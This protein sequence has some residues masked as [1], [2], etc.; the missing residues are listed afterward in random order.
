V[1]NSLKQMI[2]VKD[3]A[4]RIPGARIMGNDELAIDNLVQLSEH[5]EAGQLCWCSEKN[6]EK[7]S[8]VKQGAI[9]C[10]NKTPTLS[11]NTGC[12]YILVD[13]PRLAFKNVV[14]AFFVDKTIEYNI[15][16]SAQLHPRAKVAKQVKIGHNAVVEEN[17]EIENGTIIGHNTVIYKGVKIGKNVKV[18][19]NCSIG[20][21]G[22]GFEKDESG[23]Y[24]R[25]PHM[26]NVIIEDD[27]E[28]AN[29]VAIDRAVIGSTLICKNVKIDNLVHIAHGVEIGENTVIIA[30]AMIAGSTKIGKNVWVAPSSSIMNKVKIGN[31]VI[32]GIGAVVLKDVPD[33]DVVVGN[34]ARSIKK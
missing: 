29:N 8:T 34:P 20:A 1:D 4:K 11:F 24:S 16:K 32:I 5:V 10:S 26:G 25:M 13:N 21:D 14:D 7:L 23:N 33:G 17:A 22:F 12:T 9:I 15:E 18:G 19:A 30:N 3:I 28:I 2:K 27:V 31:N 6:T